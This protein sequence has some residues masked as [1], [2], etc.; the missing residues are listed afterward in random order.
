MVVSPD[1]HLDPVRTS[2]IDTLVDMGR[3]EGATRA[4]PDTTAF[5]RSE[6]TRLLSIAA[7]LDHGFRGWVLAML[8]R[9]RHRAVTPSL[10]FDA[11]TVLAHCLRARGVEREAERRTTLAWGVAVGL[12]VVLVWRVVTVL[13]SV[14]G[15]EDPGAEPVVLL[16]VMVAL[17][18]VLLAPHFMGRGT[19]YR[20]LMRI[21]ALILPQDSARAHRERVLRILTR[22]LSEERFT[23][24]APKAAAEYRELLDTIG[25]EQHSP[26]VVYGAAAPF[27]GAG[28]PLQRWSLALELSPAEDGER[29]AHELT[30]RRI[31]DL[32]R[33]QLESLT[34]S[35]ADDSRDRL[36]RLE[37]AEHV[38]LPAPLPYG[39]GRDALPVGPPGDP[40]VEWHL[41]EAVGEGGETRRHFLR[42]RIAGWEE[43]LVTTVFVRVHTQG[44]MLFLEVA[45]HVLFPLQ[46]KFAIMG[47][48]VQAATL[49]MDARREIAEYVRVPVRPKELMRALKH[50][51]DETPD[52]SPEEW[53]LP[54]A[55]SLREWTSSDELTLFQ[56]MDVIRYVKT[57]HLRISEGVK[58]ALKEAGYQTEEFTA[59]AREQIVNIGQG[60]VF[61]AG[62]VSGGA[63]ATGQ[64][65]HAQHGDSEGRP[66]PGSG[67]GK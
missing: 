28:A 27:R 50:E 61:I 55:A 33:P 41:A 5:A 56:A 36:G 7:Y 15:G 49:G 3:P 66:R 19:T 54:P 39:Q 4:A 47:G 30:A 60:G 9:A 13:A 17:A 2:V 44:R 45:P 12:V 18:V 11:V 43:Q 26:V 29:A 25:R 14:V 67:E 20:A 57:V 24:R 23:G 22:E 37:I 42:I 6:V 59:Q 16:L 10:G 46:D 34:E 63:F 64:G 32:V 65:A 31:I 52:W 38:F 8:V 62:D 51:D 35:A 21:R 1:G 40:G 58:Q 53:A 48:I